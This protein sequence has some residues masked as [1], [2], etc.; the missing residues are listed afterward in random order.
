LTNTRRTGSTV[1]LGAV[2]GDGR[3][4]PK[5]P[6]LDVPKKD[7]DS[8]DSG[9]VPAEIRDVSFPVSLRG[10][11][12][13]AVDDYVTRV[14]NLISELEAARSPEAAVKHALEELAE[15]TSGIL[16]HAGETAE[17]IAVGARRQ[18]DDTTASAEK[19]A[20]EI[21]ARATKEADELRSASKTEAETLLAQTR[22]EVAEQ[23]ERTEAE[24]TALRE[25]AE[26]RMRRLES[27]TDSVHDERR[28]LLDDV[29]GVAARVEAAANEADE[30]F[31]P[32][33]HGRSKGRAARDTP[34]DAVTGDGDNTGDGETT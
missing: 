34:T 8:D 1:I 10:Y 25:E 29:R 18:A 2:I 3:A 23:R 16:R 19:E 13:D 4:E 27:D 9:R 15:R 12:R 28:Q 20:A 24:L 6:V 32:Q 5:E 31:P 30:R 26:E 22:A 14:N 17:E 33:K 21:V 7:G 11:D